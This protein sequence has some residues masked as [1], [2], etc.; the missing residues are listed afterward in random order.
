MSA[1]ADHLWNVGAEV[2]LVPS[3][4]GD[5]RFDAVTQAATVVLS[6]R[7][8]AMSENTASLTDPIESSLERRTASSGRRGAGCL[9]PSPCSQFAFLCTPA[10]KPQ[11]RVPAKVREW[12]T[13]RR[14]W[15]VAAF[16]IVPFERHCLRTSR[17]SAIILAKVAPAIQ[18]AVMTHVPGQMSRP[19]AKAKATI[20]PSFPQTQPALSL[21]LSILSP[22]VS[23][24][25]D[26]WPATYNNRGSPRA[27]HCHR[28]AGHVHQ[29]DQA[30]RE[31]VVSI[32]RSKHAPIVRLGN[33]QACLSATLHQS[34]LAAA[35]HP[36]PP[37]APP[38]LTESQ[39]IKMHARRN[40]VT[41]LRKRLPRY[42]PIAALPRAARDC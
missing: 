36:P 24:P 28:M 6:W 3:P 40:R 26:Y 22:T 18:P 21:L 32:K 10:L 20:G 1:R 5:A 12:G 34:K 41:L 42:S 33:C 23:H 9:A 37:S 30:G 25:H 31:G 8:S 4:V 14:L 7:E 13:N 11:G 2:S 29:N 16:V 17:L 35:T 38:S 15:R 19:Q 39:R 27:T